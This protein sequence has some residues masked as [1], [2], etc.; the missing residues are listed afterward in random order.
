MAHADNCTCDYSYTCAACQ[1][2]IDAENQK[3]YL[4]EWVEWI[5]VVAPQ[6]AQA[7]GVKLPPFPKLRG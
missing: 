2:L 6:M 5:K 3:D 1:A 4:A 7:L